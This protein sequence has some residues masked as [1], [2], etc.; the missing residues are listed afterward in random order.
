MYLLC[1]VFI[2]YITF[3]RRILLLAVSQLFILAMLLSKI[4]NV[5]QD[6]PDIVL[7][8]YFQN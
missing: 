2:V 4:R 6:N 8:I 7:D 1:M 5:S 3:E